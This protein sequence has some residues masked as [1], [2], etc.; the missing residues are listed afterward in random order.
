MKL[1]GAFTALVTP[2][3]KDGSVDIGALQALVDTQLAAG[4]N[5]LVPC[6]TTG[7]TATLDLAERDTVVSTV[8]K[9]VNGRVPVI[10]GTGSNSTAVTITNQKRIKELGASHALVVTP[11]YNKPTPDGLYAHF[12]AIADAVDIPSVLYNVPGRT[13]VDMKPE[14]VVKL[15]K[16][17]RIVGL[18]DATNDLDRVTFTARG[19]GKDFAQLSGEDGTSCAFT[20]MGGDGVISVASNVVPAETTQMIAHALKGEV[21]K[22]REIHAKLRDLVQA[23]FFESNPIPAKAALAMMGQMGGTLR[24]PLVE[25]TTANADKL[26]AVLTAGGWLY[27]TS[28]N[29]R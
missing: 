4:I 12:T 20:L 17:E 6:G 13:G 21:V 5:G 27:S 16:H 19:V 29:P 11:F 22:A 2:F 24:M 18:K 28:H 7:E 1:Q 9:R 8:V 25:M 10:A 26:R 14:T 3:N 23:L 15:A